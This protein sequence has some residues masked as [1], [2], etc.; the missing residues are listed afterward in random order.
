MFNPKYLESR[1]DKKRRDDAKNDKKYRSEDH[2]TR[3][4]DDKKR[5]TRAK[6]DKKPMLDRRMMSMIA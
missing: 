2:E 3:S 1:D 4:K 6:D 5:R